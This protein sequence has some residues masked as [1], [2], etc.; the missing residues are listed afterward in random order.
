MSN[1]EQQFQQGIRG[2]PWFREFTQKHGEPNLNDP[3]YD[4]RAAWKSGARPDVRDPGDGMLHWPSQFKG[5]DHPNRFDFSAIPARTIKPP[6]SK[7][8]NRIW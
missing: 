2:T 7:L 3:N 5:P 6:L 1:E 8:S 4:Y